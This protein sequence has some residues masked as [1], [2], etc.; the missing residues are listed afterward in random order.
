MTDTITIQRD[1]AMDVCEAL[2]K[3][4]MENLNDSEYQDDPDYVYT[5]NVTF[6]ISIAKEV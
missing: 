4:I 6:I 2:K 1:R 3:Y 5:G